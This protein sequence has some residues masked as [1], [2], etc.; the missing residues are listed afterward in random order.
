MNVLAGVLTNEKICVKIQQNLIK[1]NIV[2][3]K[4][5]D[6]HK[7]YPIIDSNPLDKKKLSLWTKILAVLCIIQCV[8]SAPI[9]YMYIIGFIEDITKGGYSNNSAST[10]I[11]S[12]VFLVGTATMIALLI[13]IGVNLLLNKRRAAAININITIIV[14]ITVIAS[15][16]MLVGVTPVV[17]ILSFAIV[18]MILLKSYIDPSLDQERKL[19]RKLRDLENKKESEDGTIGFTKED[20]LVKIN[21]FN[22]FWL[23]FISCIIGYIAEI[24]WHMTI[25]NPGVYQERAGLLFGPFSP[26]Y[27]FGAVIITLLL[28]KLSNK[29]VILI[30]VISALIG[31]FFEYFASLYLEICFGVNSWDYS[32]LPFNI[33]GRT[34]LRFFIIWGF[35]GVIWVKY[36]LH[37]TIKLINK[38]P[39]KLRYS[40]TYISSALIIINLI[41]TFQAL[42]CWYTRSSGHTPETPIEE[43][44]A[45]YFNDDFMQY[46]FE[47]MKM[48]PE[49]VIRESNSNK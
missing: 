25:D 34:S 19:Q 10:I 35:I 41:M 45:T 18:L 36:L 17:Y 24:I 27:G 40:L 37:K 46:R 43:F 3:A 38:I 8:I 32:H 11:T 4:K 47:N 48:N 5:N 49:S 7:P 42:D 23:F 29:N 26:I 13:A 31:G 44:Y 39:W 20:G 15:D 12:I 22:M 21:Y 6:L 9:I 1:F 2:V 28:Y 16:I 14:V 30:F 33:D